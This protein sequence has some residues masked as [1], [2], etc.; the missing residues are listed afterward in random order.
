[1]LAQDA[2][3]R[4]RRARGVDAGQPEAE[5]RRPGGV[6]QRGELAQVLDAAPGDLVGPLPVARGQ[7]G[8]R[9]FEAAHGVPALAAGAGERRGER[10]HRRLHAGQLVRAERANA[11][12]MPRIRRSVRSA[13]PRAAARASSV[14]AAAAAPACA[15]ASRAARSAS[16]TRAIAAST[17]SGVAARWV[18]VIWGPSFGVGYAMRVAR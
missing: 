10:G 2:L 8:L 3:D 15:T 1:V 6:E 9:V 18:V 14:V 7:P 12:R 11:A 16:S 17:A 5:R 13:R 4:V